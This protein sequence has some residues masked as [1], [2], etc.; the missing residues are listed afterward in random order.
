MIFHLRKNC[1][2]I[3]VLLLTI[4]FISC[5]ENE[6]VAVIDPTDPMEAIES[7]SSASY[8]EMVRFRSTNSSETGLVY[9]VLPGPA[10]LDESQ[11]PTPFS[12][13]TVTTS[14]SYSYCIDDKSPEDSEDSQDAVAT[15]NIRFTGNDGREFKIDKIDAIHK[16]EGTGEHTFFGGTAT[17]KVIHGNT[18]VGTNLEPKLLAYIALWGKT[19]LKDANTGEVIAPNR[20]IHIMT[21]S[22]VRDENLELITSRAIDSTDHNI[23]NAQTHVILPPKDM[24]GNMDPIP[25][26][27]HGFLHMMFGQVELTDANRDPRLVYEVLPGPAA[28]DPTIDPSSFS[29]SIAYAA[30][31]YSYTAKNVTEND[32]EDSEDEVNDFK[33]EFERLGGT[34]FIIDNVNVIHKAEGTGGHT[35]FG[36]V[37]NDRTIHGNTGVGTNLEP[38]L[39][40]YIAFWGT[41]DL[42]DGDGNMLASN[43]MIH[44]MTTSRVRTDNLELI[45]DTETDQTDHSLDKVETH[46]IL[47]PMD[48]DG[49]MSPVPGSGHGFLHLMF[50]EVTLNR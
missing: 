18:G 37:G 14:G 21:T 44:V 27:D 42:K 35:F 3:F 39:L 30:G 6:T 23:R 47:P 11:S 48:L 29:N 10:A 28:I 36:G 46:I 43:R 19:D 1:S 7:S 9:E 2:A 15:V 5:E 38:K 17:N 22:N 12:N 13:N 25:G 41:A 50:E 32:S 24:E 40:A 31:S 33:V 45:T 34:T 49:N 4:I 8:P 20:M 16:A 26:T